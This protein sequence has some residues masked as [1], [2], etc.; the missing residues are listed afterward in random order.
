MTTYEE[1][2]D[3]VIDKL[4]GSI[5]SCNSFNSESVHFDYFRTEDYGDQDPI[6][7]IQLQRDEFDDLGPHLT[8]H[9]LSFQIIVKHIGVGTKTNLNELIAYLSEIITKIE[10]DRTLGST[11]L[12]VH[13]TQVGGI[14][15]SM[16]SPQNA[17]IYSAYMTLSVRAIRNA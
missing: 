7:L 15:Y 16:S 11:H 12:D 8:N 5:A 4:E 2:L 10:S 17:V 9:D 6:C 1:V 3:D 14:E 13:G